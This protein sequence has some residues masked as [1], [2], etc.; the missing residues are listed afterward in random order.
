MPWG[1]QDDPFGILRGAS[2]PQRRPRN[3]ILEG[4]PEYPK[5]LAR[6]G[7]RAAVT[8]IANLTSLLVEVRSL[9]GSRQNG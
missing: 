9:S 1:L 6:P 7:H 8:R 2:H 4:I 5:P 3:L